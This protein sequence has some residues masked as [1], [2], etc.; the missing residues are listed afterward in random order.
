VHPSRRLRIALLAALLAVA[1]RP[2][3]AWA[4]SQAAEAGIGTAAALT[5][6]VYGPTK[7]VYATLGLVIGGIAWGLSGG[8]SAVMNAI[9]TPAVRGDYVVTPEQ[10]RGQRALEFFGRDPAYRE[11][12]DVVAD[13]Y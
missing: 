13:G 10:L 1:L 11:Q 7:V 6:L 9:I 3:P 8:D 12:A 5:T 4:D 2:G